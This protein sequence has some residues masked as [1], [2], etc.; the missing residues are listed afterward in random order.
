M[1]PHDHHHHISSDLAL[2][3][4]QLGNVQDLKKVSCIVSME[5]VQNPHQMFKKEKS[6]YYMQSATSILS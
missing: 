3:R 5:T 2:I 4:S 6:G 1:R